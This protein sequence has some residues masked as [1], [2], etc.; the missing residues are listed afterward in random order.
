MK[1]HWDVR[2]AR[3]MVRPLIGTSVTPNHLTSLRLIVGLG[4][5]WAFTAGDFFWSN[6]GALGFAFS[7]LL[8]HTDG[9]FARMTGQGSIWGHRYD[10]ACDALIHILLFVCMGI[11]LQHQMPGKGAITMGVIAG[12]SITLIFGLRMKLESAGGK[13]TTQ[14]PSFAGFDMEDILYFLP[15][16]TLADGLMVFLILAATVSPWVAVFL[17]VQVLNLRKP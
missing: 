12:V 11:G 3:R 15:M 16:V 1:D 9:E 13:G 14:L 5:V 17:G 6:I 8:D 2:I 7:N 10:L 4:A